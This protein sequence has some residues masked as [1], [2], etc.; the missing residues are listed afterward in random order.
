LLLI[1]IEVHHTD[2]LDVRIADCAG[3]NAE[4]PRSRFLLMVSDAGPVANESKV[5]GIEEFI[6]FSQFSKFFD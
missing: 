4:A 5:A 2:S 1:E 6:V 3:D